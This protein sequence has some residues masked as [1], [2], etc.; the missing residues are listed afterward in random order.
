MKKKNPFAALIVIGII[1]VGF[2]IYSYQNNKNF[3]ENSVQTDG[4][5]FYVFERVHDDDSDINSKNNNIRSVEYDINLQISF[6]TPDSVKHEFSTKEVDKSGT[7]TEG[8]KVTVSYDPKN[9][10]KA[11]MGSFDNVKYPWIMI[12]SG[13]GSSLLG[14]ILL[15][16]R[17]KKA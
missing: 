6:Y 5:I 4:E 8:Q 12:I 1:M 10:D 9:P 7:Y 3:G 15:I 13:A 11:R 2:S 16:F 14:L 17:K